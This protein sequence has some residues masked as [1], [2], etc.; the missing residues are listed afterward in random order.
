MSWRRSPSLEVVDF[1]LRAGRYLAPDDACDGAV[2]F[3]ETSEELP[4]ASST[5]TGC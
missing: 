4:P 3:L 5:C 1:Q 2:L